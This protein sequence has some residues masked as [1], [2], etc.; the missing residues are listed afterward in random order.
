M[1]GIVGYGVYLPKCRIK[2]GEIG[3]IWPLAA[4]A[5]G[6]KEKAVTNS[7]EDTLTMAVAA[8]QNAVKHAGIDPA[9]IGAVYFGTVSSPYVEKSLAVLLSEVLGL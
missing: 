4:P 5:P 9:K 3:K 7:D 1:V 2:I 6:I 8:C